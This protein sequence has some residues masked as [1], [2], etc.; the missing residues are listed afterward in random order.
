MRVVLPDHLFQEDGCEETLRWQ[1]VPDSAA[2]ISVLDGSEHRI[3][4]GAGER[5]EVCADLP[6][7]F[8]PARAARRRATEAC[9]RTETHRAGCD[10]AFR[11]STERSEWEWIARVEARAGRTPLPASAIRWR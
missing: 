8:P 3:L 4:I 10:T 7:R 9:R 2:H 5:P 11:Q 6:D 1:A